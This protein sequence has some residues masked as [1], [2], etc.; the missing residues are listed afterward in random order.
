MSV[1]DWRQLASRQ[2]LSTNTN[3]DACLSDMWTGRCTV[4]QIDFRRWKCLT[5]V[6]W[7]ALFFSTYGGNHFL[8]YLDP[9]RPNDLPSR[10][11]TDS[12][13]T[14]PKTPTLDS[15]TVQ[16]IGWINEM[17]DQNGKQICSEMSDRARD[18]E[19]SRP[20]QDGAVVGL[21][22]PS[23][24][25]QLSEVLLGALNQNLVQFTLR[26]GVQVTVYAAH[27]SAGKRTQGVCSR[28]HRRAFVR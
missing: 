28:P 27:L 17:I 9:P 12:A 22:S 7:S 14:S 5:A 18:D 1:F 11:E 6:K 3:V 4:C 20:Q 25:P 13:D 23:V 8:G 10:L 21:T 15:V 19:N 26:P 2:K 16:R 24:S